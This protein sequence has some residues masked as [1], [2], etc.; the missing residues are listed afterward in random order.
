[1]DYLKK[2]IDNNDV[3][4]DEEAYNYIDRSKKYYNCIDTYKEKYNID[5]KI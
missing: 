5:Q 1:M 2:R 4:Y 3:K